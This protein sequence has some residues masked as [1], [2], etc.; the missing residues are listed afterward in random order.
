MWISRAVLGAVLCVAPVACGVDGETADISSVGVTTSST[1]PTETTTT[2]PTTTTTVVAVT[3]PSTTLRRPTSSTVTT[4]RGAGG[5][6]MPTSTTTPPDRPP[7]SPSLVAVEVTTDR[8][9]YR[10]GET[11]RVQ[12]TLRNQSGTACYYT[13]YVG[14]HRVTGPDGKPVLP[15][16]MFVADAFRDT[17]LA[18]G[19]T[20]TQSPTWD[21]QT[22]PETPFPQCTQAAPGTYSVTVEWRF[23][24]EP[25]QA[26]A[27]FRLVAA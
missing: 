23:G 16:S 22:C 14:G 13:S 19:A 5:A 27:S 9:T 18:S 26:S 10:P 20:L 12:A 24:G 7:C 17:A 11:V 3:R 2:A 25:A 4:T 21:Q 15:F 6:P 1:L 8:A